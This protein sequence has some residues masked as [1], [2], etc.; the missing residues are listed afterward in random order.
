MSNAD[1]K[2][3]VAFFSE[4]FSRQAKGTAI[5]IQKLADQLLS[6]FSGQIELTLIRKEG[7]CG[8]PTA[9][10]IRNIEIRV[11]KTPV[12]STLISYLI[13]FLTNREEFDAV[14]FNRN[15]YPGFWFLNARKFILFL[16]DAPVNKIYKEK[17]SFENR[18]IYSFIKYVGKYFLDA[19]IGVSDDASRGLIV[20]FN[21]APSQVRT[22]YGGVGDNYRLFSGQEKIDFKP[23]LKDKYGIAAPYILDVSR[24]EPHKNIT[25]LIDAFSILKTR[26]NI[27]H[28][29]VIIG[30]RHLSDYNKMIDEK[31][32]KLNLSGD[33]V[34]AP[35]IAE[36]DMPAVYNSA[37]LLI[38]PSLLEGFGLPVVEAMKCGLPVIASNLP[39]MEEVADGAAVLADPYDAKLLAEKSMEILNNAELRNE[40]IKKGLDR[41]KFFSWRSSARELYK[42]II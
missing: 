33:V 20:Y 12:F 7:F 35:Y 16:Y 25:T 5:V 14:I 15:V 38:F 2:L 21:L 18:L 6:D 30:G 8:H 37:D 32:S 10:K 39:V 19:I 31:I 26:H 13:F 4:D 41:S 28:K 42:I 40:L 17:L 23:I 24:L 9:K 27:P 3:K 22:V 29:L 34:I 36:E 11:Y 1:K